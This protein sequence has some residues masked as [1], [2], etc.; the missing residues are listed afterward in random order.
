MEEMSK[1]WEPLPKDAAGGVT[2][3]D[4]IVALECV[5]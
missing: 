1:L 3:T 2:V 5:F 4:F